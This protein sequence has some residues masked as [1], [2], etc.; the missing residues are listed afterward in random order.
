MERSLR[1]AGSHFL[2]RVALHHRGVIVVAVDAAALPV[3]ALLRAH[4]VAAAVVAEGTPTQSENRDTITYSL[5][6]VSYSTGI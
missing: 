6:I 1:R 5:L 2:L 3:A 4:C